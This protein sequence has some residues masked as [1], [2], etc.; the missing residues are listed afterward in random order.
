MEHEPASL[1]RA[2]IS[3]FA[4]VEK[5]ALVEQLLRAAR[6]ERFF[7]ARNER[8]YYQ[9]LAHRELAQQLRGYIRDRSE[10]LLVRQL[11]LTIAAACRS[12]HNLPDVIFCLSDATDTQIHRAAASEI[13]D[14]FK[15]SNAPQI[16]ALMRSR[17]ATVDRRTRFW[18]AIA[19]LRSNSWSLSRI[20]PHAD[21]LL[22]PQS[23][24]S[25]LFA[26][27]RK[28]ADLQVLLAFSLKRPGSHN[29]GSAF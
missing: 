4:V 1:L 6:E 20:L 11:A 26:Q 21:L 15:P 3:S 24:E 5:R 9:G 13:P 2:D 8:R 27:Y 19:L 22:E 17:V 25:L 7:D 10:K 16:A 29:I 18:C 23:G 14:L 12:H 28:P